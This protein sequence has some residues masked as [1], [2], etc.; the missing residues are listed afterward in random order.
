MGLIRIACRMA[1]LSS[2][3]VLCTAA[4]SPAAAQEDVQVNFQLPVVFECSVDPFDTRVAEPTRPGVYISR[5]P[6]IFH[7][8]TNSFIGEFDFNYAS[9][10]G[11][12]AHNGTGIQTW[13]LFRESGEPPP[14]ASDPRW[15]TGQQLNDAAPLMFVIGERDFEIWCKVSVVQQPPG[16]YTCCWEI[17]LNLLTTTCSHEAA[18]SCHL[19]RHDDI[20]EEFEYEESGTTDGEGR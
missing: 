7:V 5:E 3:C 13:Y 15:K 14:S 11:N 10:P 20:P 6:L 8:T 4:D 17:T 19:P 1:A 2:L 16:T 12:L 9:A 18:F